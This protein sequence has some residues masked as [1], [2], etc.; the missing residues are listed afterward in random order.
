MIKKHYLVTGG[1]GFIGSA[2]VKALVK[3]GN[4][5]RILDN[6]LRGSEIRIKGVSNVEFI[7][8]DIRD[9]KIVAKATKG[10]DSIIHLAFVNGTDSFYSIP[11]IVLDIGVK[12]IINIIDAAIK[13]SIPEFI[14]A[15]SSEVYQTPPVV[16]TPEDVRMIIPDPKNPRYSYAGGKMIG[17]LM[18]LNYGKKFFKRTMIFRPHNVFGPDMGWGHVIP[19]F[20]VRMSELIKKNSKKRIDFP[21]QGTGT[22]TRAFCY[23]DDFTE[24]LSKM[25]EKGSNL[26]IYNIGTD[27]EVSIK[28]VAKLVGKYFNR[29]ISV[30]PGELLKGGTLRRCPDISKLRELGY[31]PSVSLEDGIKLTADWYTKHTNVKAKPINEKVSL[32]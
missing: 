19:Q 27:S 28:E 2:L 14:F 7:K 30:K 16:P 1:T 11:E 26:E 10:V 8:G 9:A 12:G 6:N 3:K 29:E 25:I 15:S 5:V 22:E 24:G 20:V 32:S 21:I 17:E 23:I 18:T 4:N 13:H 31:S